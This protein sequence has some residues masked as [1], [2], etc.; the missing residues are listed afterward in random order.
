MSGYCGDMRA[1]PG[2]TFNGAGSAYCILH[3]F[4]I[5]HIPHIPFIK[6]IDMRFSTTAL[7]VAPLAYASSHHNSYNHQADLHPG[8]IQVFLHPSPS[9]PHAASAV[10]TLTADQA[11]AV[12]AHHMGDALSDFDEIPANE[13]MW[14]HLMGLWEKEEREGRVVIVDGGVSPQ[15]AYYICP[16]GIYRQ[17]WR[18]SATRPGGVVE[19]PA[20]HRGRQ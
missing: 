13:G 17:S 18:M 5:A 2:N 7:F 19:W 14:G 11:K 10:P 16:G 6:C 15:C 1:L 12:L 20:R 4:I 9:S 3:T 8:Q